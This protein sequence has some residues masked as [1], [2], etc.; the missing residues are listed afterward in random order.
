LGTPPKPGSG[1]SGSD[2]RQLR[3]PASGG[4]KASGPPREPSP[5]SLERARIAATAAHRCG[6]PRG[7]CI[8]VQ[9]KVSPIYEASDQSVMICE[10]T[11][12]NNQVGQ[13]IKGTTG[14][15]KVLCPSSSSK[16]HRTVFVGAVMGQGPG[17]VESNSVALFRR[18]GRGERRA[19]KT[20]VGESKFLAIG[21]GARR[22]SAARRCAGPGLRCARAMIPWCARAGE[23][24]L[25]FQGPNPIGSA[26]VTMTALAGQVAEVRAR[27]P[28]LS[29]GEFSF[30]KPK[31][32][33]RIQIHRRLV[34][35]SPG[36]GGQGWAPLH[37]RPRRIAGCSR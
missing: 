17:V 2:P 10:R 37:R 19:P 9:A 35:S 34:L 23:Q 29:H 1:V 32:A 6:A 30:V 27:R 20:M 15:K 22:F 21:C 31:V 25:R 18:A 4:G 3:S 26:P 13:G 33:S 24:T 11:R 8:V 14:E 16:G 5:A 28:L 36:T 12:P 7:F